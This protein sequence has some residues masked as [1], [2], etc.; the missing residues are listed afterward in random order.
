MR[1]CSF[2]IGVRNFCCGAI[3]YDP[4]KDYWEIDFWILL[5]LY[6]GRTFDETRMQCCAR[7][8]NKK[9]C[10]SRVTIP[11]S[12]VLRHA[13]TYERL[14]RKKKD[15][16]IDMCGSSY[17]GRNVKSDMAQHIL[18]NIESSISEWS[19]SSLISHDN[20]TSES[21]ICKRHMMPEAICGVASWNDIGKSYH[22]SN[23]RPPENEIILQLLKQLDRHMHHFV[24]I[25]H[26]RIESQT[27]QRYATI[28]AAVNAWLQ[29]RLTIDRGID[30]DIRNMHAFKK[31]CVYDGPPIPSVDCTKKTAHDRNKWFAIRHVAY[32]L[33]QHPLAD[34]YVPMFE[35]HP[36]RDDLADVLLMCLYTAQIEV[37]KTHTETAFVDTR[38]KRGGVRNVVMQS[39]QRYRGRRGRR[40]RG[41]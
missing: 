20:H 1:V 30:I 27:F 12:E 6:T 14:L 11:V 37:C 38:E 4:E 36:K 8:K 31:M 10:A 15:E 18:T 26:F 32:I 22:C 7:L 17:E 5:D 39:R 13:P 3:S 35:K 2:D 40:G 19:E 41:R 34:E 29:M 16:L 25:S 33:A 23:R 9:Q 21:Y 28:G 24:G